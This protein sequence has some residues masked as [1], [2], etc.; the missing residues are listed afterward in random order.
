MARGKA[1]A[2]NQAA[3]P[4]APSSPPTGKD[5][6]NAREQ[7]RK[8]LSAADN[9]EYNR[10]VTAIG[11]NKNKG[12][13]IYAR[14]SKSLRDFL[15][16]RLRAITPHNAYAVIRAQVYTGAVLPTFEDMEPQDDDGELQR[17]QPIDE[18]GVSPGAMSSDEFT[19]RDPATPPVRIDDQQQEED[20]DDST[21]QVSDVLSSD[22]EEAATPEEEI[23]ISFGEFQHFPKGTVSMIPIRDTASFPV[24]LIVNWDGAK[25]GTMHMRATDASVDEVQ[26]TLADS[27]HKL[28]SVK[29]TEVLLF[30]LGKNPRP[31]VLDV[32]EGSLG[33]G[34]KLKLSPI[35]HTEPWL[36]GPDSELKVFYEVDEDD[37]ARDSEE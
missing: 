28:V 5:V 1:P 13:E 2:Q 34:K 17:R 20:D 33:P 29:D 10:L 22:D 26:I 11:K 21:I 4:V 25:V 23:G 3:D 27:P 18:A 7:I 8:A 31:G 16:T 6:Q 12:P 35:P 14:N 15:A 32:R 36:G 9:N 37:Y 30:L 24:G 19:D